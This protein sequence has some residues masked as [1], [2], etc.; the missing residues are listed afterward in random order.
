MSYN[1]L[2][3]PDDIAAQIR[4]YIRKNPGIRKD[5]YASQEDALLGSCYVATEA[6][7]HADGAKDSLLSVNC[8][9]WSDVDP[10]YDGTHWFLRNG[11]DIV[12]LSLPSPDHAADI[13]WSTARSRV[14]ITGYTP[15][16]RTQTILDALSL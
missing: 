6:Y 11:Q 2:V 16:Q 15:S 13:P 5:E 7:W 3:E 10:S 12:D 9:S 4:E 14:P 1:I 8:L